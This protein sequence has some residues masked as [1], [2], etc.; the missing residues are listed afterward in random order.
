MTKHR[1]EEVI[2]NSGNGRFLG[3]NAR[4]AMINVN[5]FHGFAAR[6]NTT[7]FV[8]PQETTPFCANGLIECFFHYFCS[9][10]NHAFGNREDRRVVS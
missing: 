10:E 8:L 7:G 3:S 4:F 9:H 6:N 2:N 1:F 5:A